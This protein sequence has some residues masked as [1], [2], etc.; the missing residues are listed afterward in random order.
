M[1]NFYVIFL[2]FAFLRCNEIMVFIIL[3]FKFKSDHLKE[4]LSK[5]NHP[6]KQ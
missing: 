2:L 5:F 1:K 3:L 4:I 6:K